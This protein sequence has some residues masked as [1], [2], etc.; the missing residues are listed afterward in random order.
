MPLYADRKTGKDRSR[1]GIVFASAPPQQRYVT[2]TGVNNAHFVIPAHAPNYE[3]KAEAT[4]QYDTQLA[5]VQPHMHLRAKDYQLSAYYPSGESEILM[6]G[7]FDF[8]W[9]LGYEFAKPIV[10]PKGTRSESIAHFDNSENNAYNPNPNIDVK[11]GPQT[12][13]EMAVSFMGFI[14][15]VKADPARLF[16]RRGRVEVIE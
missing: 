8:N 6:K 5:W 2:I 14:I 16:Q 7:G 4:V 9:Q 3:V 11:Y 1:V 10:L 12:T 15:D 13:D